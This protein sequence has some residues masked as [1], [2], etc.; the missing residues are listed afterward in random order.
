MQPNAVPP[1]AP[2]RAADFPRMREELRRLLQ[3]GLIGAYDDVEVIELF[4]APRG[5]G[6]LNVLSII[7]LGEGNPHTDGTGATTYLT[8]ERIRIN[9][10]KDWTFGV[11]RTFRPISALDQALAEFSNKGTW[12]ISGTPLAIGPLQA[13]LPAFAPPDG[14]VRVPI[15]RLLKNN[16]WNGSY[17]FRLL[18]LEKE[19]F[20][21]FFMDR[22]R[23]QSLS[24]AIFPYVPLALA[25]LPDFLG[26]VL[27]QLPVTVLVSDVHTSR[28]EEKMTVSVRWHPAATLRPL[29]ITARGRSDELLTGAAVSGPFDTTTDLAINGRLHPVESELWD[30]GHNLV[31]AATASTS[32]I[33]RV[34]IDF[35]IMR[36]EPRLFTAPDAAGKPVAARISLIEHGEPSRIGD[37]PTRGAHF[38]MVRR[39]ELEEA[40]RL[41][42]TRDFVLYRPA[43]GSHD[44]RERAL[45]DIRYLIGAHG[46][47]GV[48]LWDPYLTADDLLQTLFWCPHVGAPLR[49]LTDGRDTPH[50]AAPIDSSSGLATPKPSFSDRQ[51]AT[52][53]QD[54]GNLEGLHLEYRTRSG[55]EGWEFHDRFLIFPNGQNGPSAWSL[56]TSVNSLGAAHHIL[57]RVSNAALVAGAFD[58]LWNALSK[59]QHVIWKSS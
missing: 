11:A 33:E 17:V 20:K 38:W 39:Q 59:P 3:P 8:P 10:F 29:W 42:E 23:L 19:P 2:T 15:N 53:A 4:A 46:A 52:F 54:A 31:L 30:D 41:A 43:A 22:R 49:G 50:S 57:Q 1:V 45:A 35:N 24:D 14:T 37:E 36:P 34:R 12:A 56:G 21:P 44:E 58:D 51:R 47:R 40:R 18:D 32:T 7:V 5:G 13:Q 6:A 55:P 28:N 16:F 9:G 48:D 27:I 26:D 25:G